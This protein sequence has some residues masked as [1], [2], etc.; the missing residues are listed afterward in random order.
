[1]KQLVGITQALAGRLTSK[2]MLLAIPVGRATNRGKTFF[3]LFH[4]SKIAH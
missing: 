2:Q 1:L 3:R 4:Q